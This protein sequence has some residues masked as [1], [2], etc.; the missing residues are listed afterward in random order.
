M[1]E[2]AR[3]GLR[4]PLAAVRGAGAG[5]LVV[6]ALVLLLA[7]APLARIGGAE[8]GPA[9]G[10]VVALAVVAGLLCGLLRHPWAWWAG[11]V[12]PVALLA[13]GALHWSLGVLGVVFGLLWG[14]MLNVRR[15]I[16][17]NRPSDV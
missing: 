6:E 3:P 11:L 13:G 12:I 9:I 7:I 8:R 15:T 1:S 10:L 17:A 5:A 2:P 14:Y 4:N 16:L